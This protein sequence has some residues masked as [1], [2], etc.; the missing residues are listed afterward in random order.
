VSVFAKVFQ[1]ETDCSNLFN[2]TF[3]LIFTE[4][5]KFV[6]L[7]FGFPEEK[8][9]LHTA[10]PVLW[11]LQITTFRQIYTLPPPPRFKSIKSRNAPVSKCKNESLFKSLCIR[12]H[13]MHRY[14][15]RKSYPSVGKQVI[16]LA[17]A[18]R[19]H[20]C[21][22]LLKLSRFDVCLNTA[23]RIN[24]APDIANTEVHS[25]IPH[26]M[27]L[28][29]I[30]SCQVYLHTAL[31]EVVIHFRVV[32]GS[33]ALPPNHINLRLIDLNNPRTKAILR[34]VFTP[35]I[36]LH[37]KLQLGFRQCRSI[38]EKNAFLFWEEEGTLFGC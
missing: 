13:Y 29:D 2:V 32:Y 11:R 27:L 18:P 14:V 34:I 5:Q 7:I 25:P 33:V 26:P 36:L 16:S 24:I 19:H 12:S 6:S 10:H 31:L 28:R 20:H 15:F 22:F 3:V 30:S 8:N 17:L 38:D 35:W 1:I 23:N 4:Y 21:L 37:I 9:N